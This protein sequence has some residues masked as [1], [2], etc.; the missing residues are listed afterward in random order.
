MKNEEL[1]KWASIAEI[2]AAVAVVVSV[3]YLAVEINGN[4]RALQASSRQDF[5]ALDVSALSVTI[6]TPVLAA[7][8]E[9]E[10]NGE[11]LTDIE[12][13]QLQRNQQLFLRIAENAYYQYSVGLLQENDWGR[14]RQYL[15]R[16]L[17]NNEY[18]IRVSE[19]AYFP[20]EFSA[21]LEEMKTKC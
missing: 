5:A 16:R 9:K 2:V 7:A 18:T 21:L 15:E 3:I 10:N 8:I 13:S 12:D 11:E 17:C 4:T 14:Y 20:M 19:V 6:D 1:Q